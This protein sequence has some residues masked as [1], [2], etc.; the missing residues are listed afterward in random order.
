M[1]EYNQYVDAVN[2]IFEHIANLKLAIMDQDN[3]SAIEN[4]ESY[5]QIVIDNANN[6]S[7]SAV[8]AKEVVN[9]KDD[10]EDIESYD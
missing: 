6:F 7:Q 4:I 5:K 3:L 8:T 10:L 9:A 2:K 1:S